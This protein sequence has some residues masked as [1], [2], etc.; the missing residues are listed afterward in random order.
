MQREIYLIGRIDEEQMIK[1]GQKVVQFYDEDPQAEIT[2]YINSSGGNPN[3]AIAF[4]D[5]VRI[6]KIVLTTM[7]VGECGSSALIILLAGS[8][9]IATQNTLFLVHQLSRN[10]DKDESLSVSE[11]GVMNQNLEKLA[12]KL[13]R[14]V[15][16]KTGK[17]M[18][19]IKAQE[20]KGT[21][22]T[23][24]EAL[25]FGFIDRII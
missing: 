23:A 8:K 10:F 20:K 2:L 17:P 6:K 16:D 25:E 5:I 9:R 19:E 1:V 15:A 18:G 12:D 7:A 13:R 22:L 4:Y 24:E 21:V 14:I 3:L 11:L